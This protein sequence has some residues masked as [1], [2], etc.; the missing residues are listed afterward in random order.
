MNATD[1]RRRVVVVV[2]VVVLAIVAV[3]FFATTT[4]VGDDH[5]FLAFARLAP[6]PFVAFVRDQHGGEFYRPLPMLVWWLLGRAA[7]GAAWPFAA[8]AFAL[9]AASAAL[10]ARLLTSLDRPRVVAG[11]AAALFFLA[12]QNLDAAS[13]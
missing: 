8:L 11:L 12:P 7:H 4:F 6:N 1:D 3:S 5:L 2:V 13:W 9:H 10:L